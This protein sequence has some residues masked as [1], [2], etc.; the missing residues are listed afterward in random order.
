MNLQAKVIEN[1]PESHQARLLN[2]VD[3][4][5]RS[6]SSVKFGIGLMIVLATA[7]ILGTLIVQAPMAEPGQI[8]QLYAPQT[9][10]VF[11]VL[12][13]FDVFHSR[14]FIALLGL[15]CLNITFASI[16][17]FPGTWQYLRHPQKE[18]DES[19]IQAL[20]LHST[21]TQSI[22]PKQLEAAIHDRLRNQGF[23]VYR[24]ANGMRTV[25]FGEKG[26]YSRLAVYVVHA[27]L[28]L[29]F[30]GAM[31]DSIFGFKAYLSLVE[32]ESSDR[33]DLRTSNASLQLPF[34]IRCDAAGVEQY[35]DG[36]PKKWW[37]D[38][39]ILQNGQPVS[40]K[41]ILV[42]D[43]MDYGGIRMFQSSFGSTG[44]PREFVLIVK[45]KEEPQGKIFS[46][47]LRPGEVARLEGLNISVR[48]LQFIPD[49]TMNG[50]E[51]HSRSNEPNNPALQ[52]EVT[53]SD[54]KQWKTWAFQNMP[55]FHGTPGLPY[56]VRFESVRMNHFTGLQIAK[57]PGQNVIWAG[58]FLMVVGLIVSF[59]FSH[60]RVWALIRT[61][62]PG[63]SLL[64]L[65]GNS[66]K[67]MLGFQKKFRALERS[68]AGL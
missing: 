37:S 27:S 32:G 62:D 39:V 34:H 11:E 15:L 23:K 44:T 59:Y 49:F 28:L 8:E 51:I 25:V 16:D 57:Q 6:L 13:L 40:R 17:R 60:Q 58:C 12:G 9:R 66:S 54:G 19:S 24:S 3:V 48:V 26:E 67:N 52:L 50:S 56:D 7:T 30:I 14:W 22:E 53:Q 63:K 55:D 5:L 68:L 10:L 29:I 4:V 36:T 64:W 45:P 31:I 1:P 33:A 35:A 38:L 20:E 42:N 41:Q 65:G 46:F 21:Q 47:P 2:K 61:N 18:L 43:P